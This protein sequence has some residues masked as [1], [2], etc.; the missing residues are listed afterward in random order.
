LPGR[1]DEDVG[2][3]PREEPIAGYFG[4]HASVRDCL[5]KKGS[6]GKDGAVVET[7]KTRRMK[8]GVKTNNKKGG[9]TQH[10][11]G[12]TVEWEGLKKGEKKTSF[13]EV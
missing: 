6:R 3:E 13:L 4:N 1:V 11:H 5:G 7:D 2:T 8:S 9:K 10:H 12:G